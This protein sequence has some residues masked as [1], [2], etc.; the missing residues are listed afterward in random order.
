MTERPPRWDE[1]P[2]VTEA[3]PGMMICTV[4]DGHRRCWLCRGAGVLSNGKGCGECLQRKYCIG[5]D[6]DGLMPRAPG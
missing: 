2:P 4:C 1:L 6:G 5:C 3:G